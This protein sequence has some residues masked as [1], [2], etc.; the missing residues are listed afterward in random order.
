MEK[1]DRKKKLEIIYKVMLGINLGE[2]LVLPI[3]LILMIPLAYVNYAV[4]W[5]ALIF[6]LLCWCGTAI[7]ANI[8]AGLNIK[9]RW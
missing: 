1:L 5:I 3:I 7:A 8:I 4:M 9:K 6:A 2:S